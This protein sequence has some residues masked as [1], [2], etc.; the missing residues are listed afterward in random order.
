MCQQWFSVAGQCFYVAGFLMIAFEWRKM[1]LADK[2]QC[3]E[4][5]VRNTAG[6]GYPV[7]YPEGWEGQ[8]PN[9][10]RIAFRN[11]LRKLEVGRSR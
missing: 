9:K 8:W 11:I 1:F 10:D 4:E 5:I 7:H 3:I 2:R 6:P